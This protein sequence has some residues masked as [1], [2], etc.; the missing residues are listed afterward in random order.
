MPPEDDTRATDRTGHAAIGDMT[1]VE[2]RGLVQKLWQQ[3]GVVPLN[4]Y[5][6][7]GEAIFCVFWRRGCGQQKEPAT[8]AH[9]RLS[10]RRQMPSRGPR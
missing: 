9:K 7:L 2:E 8:Q 6:F 1:S 3:W 5:F 4:Q 10:W